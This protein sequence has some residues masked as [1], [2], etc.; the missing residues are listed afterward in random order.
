MSRTASIQRHS[1]ETDITLSLTVDGSSQIAVSTGYGMLDHMLTLAFFWAGMDL[2]L[3]CKGDLHVDAH[4]SAED[5][6]L[7]LGQ[8]LAQ[9]LGERKGIARVG[10]GRVPM[11]EALCEVTIDISGRPWLEWRGDD[12]LPPVISGEEKDLWREFYKAFASAARLNL[13][14]CLLYGKNGHH[15]LESIAKGFGI[16]LAQAV[17]CQ[18]DSIR[19]TKGGLD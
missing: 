12:L 8:A 7:C 3:S 11:D 2:N 13:H 6:A 17:R 10:Y 18:G 16:A 5:V 15:L 14:I 9:A 19:S 1:A 4:H